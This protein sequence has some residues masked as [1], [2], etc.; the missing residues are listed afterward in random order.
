MAVTVEEELIQGSGFRFNFFDGANARRSLLVHGLDKV[1]VENLLYR[2]WLAVR[3]NTSLGLYHPNIPEM[4]LT[5]VDV[6]PVGIASDQARVFLDYRSLGATRIKLNGNIQR[7]MTRFDS[8]GNVIRALYKAPT[9]GVVAGPEEPDEAAAGTLME[10]GEAPVFRAGAVL[11]FERVSVKGPF[12]KTFNGVDK[13]DRFQ[14]RINYRPWQGKEK[15]TWLCND[16]SGQCLY[17]WKEVWVWLERATFTFLG[18]ALNIPGKKTINT[19]DPI[20]FFIDRN[21]GRVPSDIDPKKLKDGFPSDF[22][23][24][25]RGNGW[26]QHTILGEVDFAELGYP[27]LTKL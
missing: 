5:D 23:E 15:H 1:P 17:M 4:V 24:R 18:N 2:A 7:E 22:V 27:D 16:I 11:E 14:G 3:Q 20:H 9:D 12:A 13:M 19:W 21:T 8:K 10:P 6:Q 25:N 26:R